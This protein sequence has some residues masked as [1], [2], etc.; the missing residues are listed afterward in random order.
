MGRISKDLDIVVSVQGRFE[1]DT[2]WALMS[3]LSCGLVLL[4]QS[5]IGFAALNAP[6]APLQRF[7]ANILEQ[8]VERHGNYG[9][10]HASAIS[11]Y[12]QGYFAEAAQQ[13][14]R[15]AAQGYA[16]AQ[17]R[18]G[19]MHDYGQGVG[20][21]LDAAVY[22]YRLAAY[23]G[24]THA[25]YALG[26]AYAHGTGVAVDMRR[27]LTWWRL[28]GLKGNANAQYNLGLVYSQGRGVDQDLGQAAMWWH[29]AAEQGDPVAQFNLG[30]MFS[31]GMGVGQDYSVA[32][33][34]LR[35]S[36]AQGYE[37]AIRILTAMERESN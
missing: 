12:G 28:A 31:R 22:W 30:V 29:K 20:R 13:W 32:E 36:A 18:F 37:D 7:S 25:I 10:A 5:G 21:N 23:Q 35:R 19:L 2:C 17:F 3:A 34:W 27:A 1:R 4:F 26:V 16:P 6:A 33:A 24:H 9:R 15:L 14:S 8:Q 11:T